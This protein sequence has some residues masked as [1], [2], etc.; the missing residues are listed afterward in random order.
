MTHVLN[1]PAS[2]RDDSIEGFAAAYGRYV[3]RVPGAAGLVSSGP[4]PRGRVTL[5]VGGGSGHYPSYAGIVGPGLADACVLGEVFTSPSADEVH[6]VVQHA[7]VGGGVVLA[8]GNYAG[9]QLNFGIARDRLLDEGIDTRVVAVT[10]DVASAPRDRADQ[11]R[12]IAGTTVVYKVGGALVDAGAPLDEVEEIMLRANALT[13]SYGVAF[14]GCTLPGAPAPLFA[15]ADDAMELGLGI[16]GEPGVGSRPRAGADELGG[17]LVER[18]MEERPATGSAR[19]AVLLNGLGSTKYEELFVLWGAV[20]SRLDRAGV[21]CVLPE[22]GE[23]VTSLDMAGCSLSITWLDDDLE[24]AWCAPVDTAAFR[25]GSHRA[26]RADAPAA[27]HRDAAPASGTTSA[28]DAVAAPQ[29]RAPGAPDGL[30]TPKPSGSSLAAAARCRQGLDQALATLRDHAAELGRLDAVAGDGDHGSGMVRGAE[31]ATA[32]ARALPA[33]LGAGHLLEVAGRAFAD[34]AGGTS[35]ALWG[36]L[37]RAAGATLD[38]ASDVSTT[39]VVAAVRAGGDAVARAGRASRGDKTMLDALLPFADA[40]E[41]ATGRG[42]PLAD[43]WVAASRVATDEAA[44]TAGL[45]ARVGRARPL[46]ERGLGTPDPGAVSAG[47]VLAAVARSPGTGPMT[48][49][50]DRAVRQDD[51]DHNKEDRT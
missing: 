47:L 1:R 29:R 7:H 46:A 6:R 14:A 43:A 44:A 48:D 16:H 34:R 33:A 8:F 12:G 17:L 40:L 5:V 2:F 10:D 21:Q 31:A 18:L 41:E 36:E 30:G 39:A 22:V 45:V 27:T 23:L 11:R 3:C 50:T 38:D 25:R 37:L 4:R 15:V 20:A 13:V 42:E 49:T 26:P 35:G 28:E 24:A 9:D 32:A 19:A 51:G